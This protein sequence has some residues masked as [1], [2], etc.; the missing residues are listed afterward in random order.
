MPKWLRVKQRKLFTTLSRE[1]RRKPLF[2]F[3]GRR[4]TNYE[5]NVRLFKG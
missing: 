4:T 2:N 5:K 3:H 1:Y